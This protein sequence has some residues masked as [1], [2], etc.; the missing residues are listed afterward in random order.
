MP[1]FDNDCVIFYS[2]AKYFNKELLGI[3]PN[4]LRLVSNGELKEIRQCNNI[5]I[6]FSPLV[7]RINKQDAQVTFF[8]RKISDITITGKIAGKI[9]IIIS[10]THDDKEIKDTAIDISGIHDNTMKQDTEVDIF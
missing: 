8:N 6:L 10:W 5:G 7:P 2:S 9:I 4:T 1:R 3:K